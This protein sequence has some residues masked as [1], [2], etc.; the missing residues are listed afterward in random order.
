LKCKKHPE[1]HKVTV[2]TNSVSFLLGPPPSEK[3]K[4]QRHENQNPLISFVSNHCLAVKENLKQ[5]C[6]LTAYIQ[7]SG[8]YTE[9]VS[10]SPVL[11]IQ[12][13]NTNNAI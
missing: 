10:I 13:F 5:A 3:R 11:L 1:K 6:P 4:L 7:S 12:I 2:T 9:S 8:A